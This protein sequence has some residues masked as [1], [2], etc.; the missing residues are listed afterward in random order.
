MPAVRLKRWSWAD[1]DGDRQIASGDAVTI[2]ATVVNYLS[3]ARGIRV[4]LAGAA[5]YPFLDMTAAEADVGFLASGDSVEVRLEFRVATNAPANQR[6]R[7]F[8]RVRGG[9]FEDSADML[10]FRV[11]HSLE[12]V[13][14]SL[15]AFYTA[16]GGDNWRRNDSWDITR[17]PT[18][19]ELNRWVGV[20]LYE[21]WLVGLRLG[22]NNLTGAIPP[23]IGNLSQLSRLRLPA[24]KLTG[25]IP[26]ELAN[27]EQ[28]KWLTLFHNDLTG[29]IPPELGSLEQLQD[30]LLQWNLLSGSIPPEFGNLEQ[31]RRLYLHNNSLSGPIPPELG[32]LAQLKDVLLDS[33]SLSGSISA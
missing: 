30:L 32:N 6:V 1:D 17:I 20:D 28:L 14:R 8:T 25:E 3:D 31:L 27:L 2:T 19:S 29:P 11:N 4:G 18:E 21:G 12:V 33:N 24:N 16:T 9:A 26:P 13:H 7:L 5:S 15:S 22:Q 23:E 10:S